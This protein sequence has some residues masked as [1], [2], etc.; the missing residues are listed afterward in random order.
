MHCEVSCHLLPNRTS[1]WECLDGSRLHQ[2][3]QTIRVRRGKNSLR[4]RRP[5]ILCSRLY[6]LGEEN[7]PQNELGRSSFA[8]AAGR[9]SYNLGNTTLRIIFRCLIRWILIYCSSS[10]D[11]RLHRRVSPPFMGAGTDARCGRIVQ[12]AILGGL[13][14]TDYRTH[15]MDGRRL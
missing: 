14:G 8:H 7:R 10:G 6:L 9:V 2:Q 12:K 5:L 3:T 1:V 11:I 13:S 15:L 4:Y